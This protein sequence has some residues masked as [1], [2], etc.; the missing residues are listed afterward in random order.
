MD[1]Y[2]IWESY[3][4]IKSKRIERVE[5]RIQK[6]TEFISYLEKE[7][8]K[9]AESYGLTLRERFMPSIRT[10]F[11]REIENVRRSASRQKYR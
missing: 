6:A 4:T 5:K 1:E 7:E 9:E 2:T 8:L 10:K 11:D 3:N